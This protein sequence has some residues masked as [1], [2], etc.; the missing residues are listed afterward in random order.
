VAD[1]ENEID[2]DPSW[3]LVRPPG[4]EAINRRKT[5]PDEQPVLT[6]AQRDPILAADPDGT[7]WLVRPD[8]TK[9][10][11]DRGTVLLFG[12]V[13]FIA[14][15]VVG[16][17]TTV[18]LTGSDQPSTSPVPVVSFTP[19]TSGPAPSGSVPDST[20]SVDLPL[21]DAA[22]STVPNSTST[23][24]STES[25][26]GTPIVVAS[27]DGV[28]LETSA[29]TTR[30]VD[31]AF[32]VVLAVGDGTYLVQAESGRDF[33]PLATSVRRV[34]PGGVPSPIL[35]PSDDVDEW[36]TLHDVTIR[37][38]SFTA[39]L[40]VA[41][42]NSGGEATEE[43]VL[44]ALDTRERRTVLRRDAS[45]STISHLSL[46]DDF[47]VG[48]VVEQGS[49]GRT[50]NRPLFLRI[51]DGP[52]GTIDSTVVGSTPFGVADSYTG[53]FVCPRVFTVDE[54]GERMGWVEGDLLVV[55]D[56]ASTQRLLL[57]SLPQGTG[58]QV[59]GIEIGERSVLLNRRL[60][61]DGPH[62]KALVVSGD[63]SIGASNFFGRASFPGDLTR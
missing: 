24:I 8:E 22:D 19:R 37:N 42:G 39:L 34:S 25:S 28:Y 45:R 47:V 5:V 60:S 10:R 55:I 41:T 49:D 48:E 36:F 21:A 20:I 43:I 4:Q 9:P 32:D 62:Q 33:D 54:A 46:G 56:V 40:S 23:T 61:R 14:M 35:E 31:G 3:D 57:V 26:V 17:I 15:A 29:G 12:V 1:D 38:G 2:D 6:P 52:D 44:V 58:E 59:M 7:S 27:S 53:C 51:T 63:G 16:L 18:A 13:T 50:T 30:I 11:D